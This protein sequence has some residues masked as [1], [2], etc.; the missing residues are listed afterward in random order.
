MLASMLRNCITYMLFWGHKMVQLLWKCLA[1]SYKTDV[2]SYDPAITLPGL[3]S[4]EMK[5]HIHGKN[6]SFHNVNNNFVLKS[7]NW[8]HTQC[9]S[10]AN[11]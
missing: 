5:T 4:R 2:L 7:K 10:T 1:V 9:H 11:G 6:S 3:Y 8:K